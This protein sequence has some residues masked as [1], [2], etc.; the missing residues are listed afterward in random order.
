M[1]LTT[2]IIVAGAV[3][4]PFL[5]NPP[6][7]FAVGLASHYALD[8]IP[9]WDWELGSLPQSDPQNKDAKEEMVVQHNKIVRDLIRVTLDVFIGLL[10]LFAIGILGGGISS[11]AIFIGLGA[12]AF[13]GI[14]PD[15]LQFVYFVMWRK[16]PMTTIQWFH[17][18]FHARTKIPRRQMALGLAYQAM[19]IA[20]ALILLVFILVMG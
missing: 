4:A 8:A 18:F 5:H 1:T 3:A 9:H 2:H 19:L 6:L 15:A 17:D 11:P 20:P 10:V 12:V 16:Q 13:G 7:A 14:L